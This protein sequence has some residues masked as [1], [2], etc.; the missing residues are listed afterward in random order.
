M[1]NVGDA[2]LR[3][4]E[5]KKN[6]SRDRIIQSC[7]K[8]DKPIIFDIG[9]HHGQSIKY[10]EE[11]FKSPVIYSFEPDPDSFKILSKNSSKN[12]KIFNHAFSNITGESYFFQNNISHTN[13][14]YEVNIDSHDSI[15]AQ[16]TNITKEVNSRININTYTLDRFFEDYNINSV[17]L[18]K[19]DTQGAEE[20]VLEGGQASLHKINVL[21]LEV[22]FYDYYVHKA[23]FTDVEKYL[24]PAGFELFSILEI[25]NN[26]MNGRTDWVEVLYKKIP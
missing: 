10:L 14:L 7:V 6:F 1:K 17:D 5:F 9:A 16:E 20:L 4:D 24:L 2:G 13:G 23:S 25:S 15:R 18:M 11:I 8:N 21:I 26:P 19:V 12:N 3:N 22:S